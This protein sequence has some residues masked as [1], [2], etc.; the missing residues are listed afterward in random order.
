M[1]LLL[2]CKWEGC[3]CKGFKDADELYKHLT[4]DHIG[5]KAKKNLCLDC[6]WQGCNVKTF[7]RDHITSHL[8]VHIPLK[9]HVCK[10][11]GKSFKRPQDLKKHEKKHPE[12][13]TQKNSINYSF[14]MDNKDPKVSN[15]HSFN[16][17][18]NYSVPSFI[19]QSTSPLTQDFKS[20]TL[21]AAQANDKFRDTPVFLNNY[22]SRA[23]SITDKM[24]SNTRSNTFPNN[25]INLDSTPLMEPP[26][27]TRKTRTFNE[28]LIYNNDKNS[29]ASNTFKNNMLLF[30][31][32]NPN[33]RSFFNKSECLTSL[34]ASLRFDSN[35]TQNFY[36][37]QAE[38]NKFI[39]NYNSGNL[40]SLNKDS[41]S[42][43]G[44]YDDSDKFLESPEKQSYGFY[45]KP[46]IDNI[47]KP[48]WSALNDNISSPNSVFGLNSKKANY[49]NLERF[50]GSSTIKPF[51]NP[52]L[53]LTRL[54]PL[55]S[56]F[57]NSDSEFTPSSRPRLNS[58]CDISLNLNSGIKLEPNL[59]LH[60]SKVSL[61][62]I[63]VLTRFIE[64]SDDPKQKN[65]FLQKAR[66]FKF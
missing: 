20:D 3:N 65:R 9:P 4:N 57:L 61:P 18:I 40:K 44:R 30:E 28:R 22:T 38:F 37:N 53:S 56:K 49:S 33:N 2:E 58:T 66:T 60:S 43:G 54:E 23:P 36:K 27:L 29:D 32:T 8:R 39:P 34:D 15:K 11:C 45:K 5:R 25:N 6:K 19:K 10:E 31:K 1:D 46:K 17:F 21:F 52:A 48:A 62:P 24:I 47:P 50:M 12:F 7:K 59:N 64:T 16:S 42:D 14:L 41:L 55:H 13:K 26:R 35:K 63:S 51:N